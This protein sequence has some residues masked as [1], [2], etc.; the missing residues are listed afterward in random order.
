[1]IDLHTHTYYSDGVL[2][3]SELVRRAQ[4]KGYRAIAIT[5][6]CDISNL[7]HNIARLRYFKETSA[8]YFDL[9]ILVGVELTHVPPRQIPELAK[10]A[11]DHGAEIIV[12]HGETIVE[13]V[14]A[15]TNEWAL[16]SD[17]DILAHPGLLSE[18]EAILAAE[19]GICLEITTRKGHSI[20]NGHVARLARR[21]GAKLVINTDAHEPADLVT[22]EFAKKVLIG[23]G[24]DK[25]EIEAIFRNSEELLGR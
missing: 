14:A 5:D 12:V 10:M 3:I 21:F 19:N 15:G 6:H 23:A 16:R 11:R 13:P 8:H 7:E 9:E 25:E 1:M 24:L 18:K 20:T 22:K 2:G 4:S 17:V